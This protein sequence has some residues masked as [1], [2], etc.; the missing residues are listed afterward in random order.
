M[1]RDKFEEWWESC[2]E[3][4]DGRPTTYEMCEMAWL[5]GRESMRDEAAE[6]AAE[7]WVKDPNVSACDRIKSIEP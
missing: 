4:K 6:I 2:H 5:A 3:F 1:S 7:Q